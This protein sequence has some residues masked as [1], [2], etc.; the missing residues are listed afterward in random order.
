[1]QKLNFIYWFS[2]YNLDSPSV[3]Y[4]GKYPLDFM[5]ENCAVN[6]Y[7]VMPGYHPRKILIFLQAYFSAL[8]FRKPN[9]TIVIQ[10]VNSNFIYANLLKFLVKVRPSNTVYDT[11]DADYLDFPTKTI[12]FFIRNCFSVSVG[13]NE[14]KQNLSHL[15]NN[16]TLNSSPTPDLQIIKKRKNSLLTIGWIGNFAGGHKESLVNF[17]FP[18]IKELPFNV[19]LVLLGVTSQSEFLFVTE[20]FRHCSNVELELPLDLDWQNERDLQNRIVQFDI[21]IATLIDDELHRSKSA[22]KLKQYFNNGV[23]VLSSA[24]PENIFFIDEGK[25]GFLCSTPGEFRKRIIEINEMNHFTY[26]KLSAN[27]R[28][29]ISKFDLTKYSQNLRSNFTAKATKHSQLL[30][31]SIENLHEPSFNM[32]ENGSI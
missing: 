15:N 19:K 12:Y 16:V 25:N 3:R 31:D 2:Y 18:S 27:A 8:F 1:M 13:S 32:T 24:I 20:Y 29:A 4:R 23:P 10:R 7:F 21:G 11:D 26:D 30:K 28:I 14:L 5:K 6:S 9:S 22:F 17:F